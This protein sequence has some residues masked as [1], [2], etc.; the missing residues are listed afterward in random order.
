MERVQIL[1]AITEDDQLARSPQAK[2]WTVVG[3]ANPEVGQLPLMGWSGRVP[4]TP[5]IEAGKGRQRQGAR[6]D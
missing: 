5:A 6:H 2:G 3:L 1:N 4:A